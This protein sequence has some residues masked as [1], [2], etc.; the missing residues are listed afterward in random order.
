MEFESVCFSREGKPGV[1]G[2]NHS[3]QGREPTTNSAMALMS[4]FQTHGGLI[5]LV[6]LASALTIPLHTQL[7]SV[8]YLYTEKLN[9]ATKEF[10]NWITPIFLLPEYF[11]SESITVKLE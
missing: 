11:W 8:I 3:E 9:N 6:R 1:P 7:S 4:G 5:H 2:E 10:I